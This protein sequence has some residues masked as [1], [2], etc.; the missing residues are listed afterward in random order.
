[1]Q[2]AE[3]RGET[4]PWISTSSAHPM[5]TGGRRHDLTAASGFGWY[6]SEY[7]PALQP[8]FDYLREQIMASTLFTLYRVLGGDDKHAGQPDLAMRQ[9]AADHA[10]TLIVQAMPLLG[11]V[12][13]SPAARIEDWI[14]ALLCADASIGPYFCRALQTWR[15]PGMAGKAIRWAFEQHG[16]WPRDDAPQGFKPRAVDL[17]IDDGRQGHYH[18]LS[19]LATDS[20]VW[21]ATENALHCSSELGHGGG[22]L[23]VV[24]ARF[25]NL[26]QTAPAA[27]G[28]SATCWLAPLGRAGSPLAWGAPAWRSLPMT[29]KSDGSAWIASASI[30]VPEPGVYGV[31]VAAEC[32]EDKHHLPT[33]G[34]RAGWPQS[35]L[36]YVV[37]L[38][39][40][41]AYRELV[42]S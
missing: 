22:R 29:V 4:F 39:N 35:P 41:L 7:G 15:L 23:L 28:L 11:A 13:V 32:E 9:A 17:Y 25:A 38:D 40:N 19:S 31:L 33:Q 20:K 1:M 24:S 26:G 18:P 21:H 8:D 3:A 30:D 12:A 2:T 10:I 42:L 16:S 14:H 36:P 6:G 37:A 27:Q 5:G 34:D